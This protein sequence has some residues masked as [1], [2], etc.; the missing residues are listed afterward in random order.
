MPKVDYDIFTPPIA[1]KLTLL[2]A[3]L[4]YDT[5]Q[6][7]IQLKGWFEPSFKLG[8]KFDMDGQ[9]YLDSGLTLGLFASA[10]PPHPTS[11]GYGLLYMTFTKNALVS[12]WQGRTS[13][14]YDTPIIVV[15]N[16]AV[17]ALLVYNP[18]S[19]SVQVNHQTSV[20]PNCETSGTY[21][22]G[23]VTLAQGQYALFYGSTK[24]TVNTTAPWGF[25]DYEPKSST[26]K[27]STYIDVTNDT[28]HHYYEQ[29]L[30][31]S[32]ILHYSK[33]AILADVAGAKLSLGN[34]AL[35]A[36][37][38]V[39]G[40]RNAD[41]IYPRAYVIDAVLS[42]QNLWMNDVYD[43][44]PYAATSWGVGQ[45]PDNV[46]YIRDDGVTY[47]GRFVKHTTTPYNPRYTQ[48]TLWK[49]K[50]VDANTINLKALSFYKALADVTSYGSGNQ[51]AH[52]GL[53]F[54]GYTSSASL[55]YYS[56]T[57][58]WVSASP[59]SGLYN[60]YNGYGIGAVIYNP[61]NRSESYR[62]RAFL[63]KHRGYGTPP[64]KVGA[65]A[66]SV[67][68]TLGEIAV[69]QDYN[70]GTIPAG[71]YTGYIAEG[72]IKLDGSTPTLSTESPSIDTADWTYLYGYPYSIS[73]SAPS[74]AYPGQQVTVTV[75]TDA[76]DGKKVY[77]V[78]KDTDAVL[79]SGIVSGG[80]ASVSFQMP[81]KNLN[82]RVYVEGADI[83]LA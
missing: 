54:L 48:I 28:L 8:L 9:I 21:S 76:P 10:I 17:G 75:A 56:P 72:V 22:G 60:Y 39:R 31:T 13:N 59:G 64:I 44:D 82:I 32:V 73:V 37:M 52:P 70:G 53:T 47:V 27:P 2:N 78:D 36:V 42:Y 61:L 43:Y 69:F 67:D 40:G 50:V 26:T 58:G 20:Y 80:Y 4:L 11:G 38:F 29:T 6:S 71:N 18:S 79:G 16:K 81:N 7:P 15:V 49:Y 23:V 77:V 65:L 35:N 66:Y 41:F 34:I 19:N 1:E 62:I 30:P 12:V 25:T 74:S 33:G 24:P 83:A 5:T 14:A 51:V 63:R 57:A 46:S 55:E 45:V 68:N 3:Q